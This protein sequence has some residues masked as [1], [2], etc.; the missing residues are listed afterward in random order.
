MKVLINFI[1]LPPTTAECCGPF[2][3][4][5]TL[6]PYIIKYYYLVVWCY[7]HCWLEAED[8]DDVSEMSGRGG[9]I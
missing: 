8:G 1:K 2:P 3:P 5:S 9:N 7:L 6:S 4:P